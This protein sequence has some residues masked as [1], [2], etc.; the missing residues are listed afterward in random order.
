[1][2]TGDGAV[3]KL[4]GPVANRILRARAEHCLEVGGAA[5]N[6]PPR[7][8]IPVPSSSDVPILPGERQR[9]TSRLALIAELR[10]RFGAALTYDEAR[11]TRPA[12]E[13]PKLDLAS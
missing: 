12:A 10:R 8:E 11:R 9:P 7:V 2:A 4:G 1:M 6:P 5:L 3:V 13:R